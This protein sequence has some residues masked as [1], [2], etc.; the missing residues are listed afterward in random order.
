MLV[1]MAGC[2][3]LGSLLASKMIEGGLRVQAFQ[4]KGA[5][6]DVLEEK[7]I[8]IQTDRKGTRK[9]YP[10]EAVSHDPSRL[11]KTRLMVVLVKSYHTSDIMPARSLLE[12]DGVVLTLQNGLG[13]AEILAEGFGDARVAAGITNYAAFRIGPGVIGWGGDGQIYLGPWKKGSPVEWVCSVLSGAGLKV[14]CIDDPRPFLW[15]KVAI[16]A[17]IN[18]L[19]SLTGLENGKLLNHGNLLT[20]MQNVCEETRLAAS[21]EGVALQ[22]EELWQMVRDTMDLTATNRSSMLQD[23]E[24]GRRTEIESIAGKILELAQDEGEFPY[25]RTLYNLIKAIDQSRFPQ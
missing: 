1:T 24:K 10:L 25:T 14:N 11:E 18:T 15:K 20:M 8:T 22:G 13:N 7:G 3:A 23:L 4:R 6:L 9:S 12:D 2:G 5:H 16:N 17:T 21:R 19:T